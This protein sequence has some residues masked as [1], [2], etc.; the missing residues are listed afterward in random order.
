M[1]LH[2][3]MQWLDKLD[4]TSYPA[5]KRRAHTAL[6]IAIE[7]VRAVEDARRNNFWTPAPLLPGETEE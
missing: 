5:S 3:V 1:T 2:E 6:K 4:H 7:A